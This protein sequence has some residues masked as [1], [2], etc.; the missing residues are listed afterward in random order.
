MAIPT[1]DLYYFVFTVTI[2]K[3]HHYSQLWPAFIRCFSTWR[4]WGW[5]FLIL[6]CHHSHFKTWWEC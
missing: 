4:A 3:G 5:M 1:S 6:Q 2:I